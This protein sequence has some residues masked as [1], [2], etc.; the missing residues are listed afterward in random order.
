VVSAPGR[1]NLIGEHTDYNDGFVL[2]MAIDR[3]VFVAGARRDDGR[4]VMRSEDFAEEFTLAPTDAYPFQEGRWH[5]YVRGIASQLVNASM[6]PD[7]RATS[8]VCDLRIPVDLGANLLIVGDVPIGAGLASSAALEVA[9]ARALCV[10]SGTAWVPLAMAQLAQRAENMLGVQCG[11]MDQLC[12]VAGVEGYGL[13]IDC[14][15]L[16]VTPKRLPIGFDVVVMDTGVRRSLSSSEYNERRQACEG[17]VTAIRALEPQ[18]RALRDVSP[19]ILARIAPSLDATL[20][21][22]ASHVVHENERVRAFAHALDASD[23][24][25]AGRLLDESHASLRD[26]YAV[27]SAQLDIICEAARAHPGCLGAR[28]TGAGFGGCAIAMV[29]SEFVADFLT[30]VPQRYEARTYKRSAFF[31]V[32]ADAGVR[33]DFAS[34]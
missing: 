13:L 25:T 8:P 27:S 16:D 32:R 28:L 34:R 26:S 33:I 6:A 12:A 9:V 14:R 10:I 5:Q 23:L 15:T 17:A 24:V 30:A 29:R 31:T 19:E 4:I 1:V 20:Q 21:Q 2:P 18:V 11:I 3:R 7:S 22:R